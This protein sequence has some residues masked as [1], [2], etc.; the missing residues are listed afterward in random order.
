MGTDLVGSP[1]VD[2]CC[3]HA[4]GVENGDIAA[5][6]KGADWGGPLLTIM[7]LL[8]VKLRCNRHRHGIPTY[9]KLC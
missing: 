5:E 2:Q 4:Y 6:G 3:V 9:F 1:G 7:G 8:K